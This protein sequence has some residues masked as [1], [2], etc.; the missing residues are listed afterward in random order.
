[1]G[2]RDTWEKT[3]NR[4]V[5]VAPSGGDGTAEVSVFPSGVTRI[6]KTAT[7]SAK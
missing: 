1:M 3:G 6:L 4:L 2:E 7:L 5:L